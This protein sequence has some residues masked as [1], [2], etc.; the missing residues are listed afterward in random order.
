MAPETLR[1][2]AHAGAE[3][4]YALQGTLSVHIDGEEHALEAGDSMYFDSGLPHGYR[5]GGRAAAPSSSRQPDP[6][7]HVDG[8][9]NVVPLLGLGVPSDCA[10][11]SM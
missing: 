1:P 4:I 6:S 5:R 8:D 9:D 7:H 3:F 11:R 10:C 2:H